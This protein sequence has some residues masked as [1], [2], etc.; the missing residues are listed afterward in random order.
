MAEEM[1]QEGGEGSVGEERIWAICADTASKYVR[2]GA[3]QADMWRL[4][5]G[6]EDA[7]DRRE[8]RMMG[9][10]VN[11]IITVVEDGNAHQGLGVSE[12]KD[13]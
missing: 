4:E 3:G 11:C 13:G 10:E 9:S 6:V 2:A 12:E 1:E 7:T 8:R 5:R